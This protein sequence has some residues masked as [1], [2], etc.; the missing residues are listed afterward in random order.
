LK[1]RD[2][3]SGVVPAG[4]RKIDGIG[5]GLAAALDRTTGTVLRAPNLKFLEGVNVLKFLKLVSRN[6]VLVN[7]V[8]AIATGE[9]AI[10]AA[11]GAK[12]AVVVAIGTG[13]GGCLIIDGKIYTGQGSA[14]QVGFMVLDSGKFFEPLAAGRTVVKHS[15]AEFARVAKYTGR[16]W[17]HW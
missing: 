3:I 9:L 1:L 12:N 11:R 14:G 2:Y 8:A 7:D 17:P 16:Q 13:I 5:M 15:R 4:V 10:G 6:A